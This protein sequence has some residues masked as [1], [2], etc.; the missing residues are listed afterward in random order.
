MRT[1]DIGGSE[2]NVEEAIKVIK[3]NYP[4]ESYSALRE[5]LDLAIKLLAELENRV[6]YLEEKERDR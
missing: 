5:A 4:P 2:M 6:D 3:S 1:K